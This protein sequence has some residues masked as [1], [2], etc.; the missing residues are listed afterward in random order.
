MSNSLKFKIIHLLHGKRCPY[1]FEKF[2]K[3][4]I[5]IVSDAFYMSEKLIFNYNKPKGKFPVAIKRNVLVMGDTTV[6]LDKLVPVKNRNAM[7][8]KRV[9]IQCDYCF[10]WSN[11]EICF[12]K[13]II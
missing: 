8:S 1:C 3:D 4:S 2:S 7:V 9:D 12:D 5:Q 13:M 6:P 10:Y 11:I